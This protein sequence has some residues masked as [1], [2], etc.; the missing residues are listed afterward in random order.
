MIASRSSAA[1][2]CRQFSAMFSRPSGNQ[3]PSR[4]AGPGLPRKPI[5]SCS[6]ISSQNSVRCSIDQRCRAATSSAPTRC[7]SLRT[8]VSPAA[9]S[10][11]HAGAGGRS[12]SR[13]EYAAAKHSRWT[14]KGIRVNGR[15]SASTSRTIRCQRCSPVGSA[16]HRSIRFAS[17]AALQTPSDV[18]VGRTEGL[19]SVSTSIPN[20]EESAGP[21]TAHASPLGSSERLR[22]TTA[23]QHSRGLIRLYRPQV[24]CARPERYPARCMARGRAVSPVSRTTRVLD[25]A[26]RRI[27]PTVPTVR[28]AAEPGGG[29]SG[30]GHVSAAAFGRPTRGPGGRPWCSA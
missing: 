22:R 13:S 23:S 11:S 21:A 1:P 16:V 8:L 30:V 24:A 5:L 14:A 18:S 19:G 26:T 4:H 29:G 2:G 28:F 6:H 27:E 17:A 9:I 7:A 10:G 15:G 20:R 3:W 25:S 12:G